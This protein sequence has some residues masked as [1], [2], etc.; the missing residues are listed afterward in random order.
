[1]FTKGFKIVN[2]NYPPHCSNGQFVMKIRA[3]GGKSRLKP[4]IILTALTILLR[5]GEMVA[6]E[7]YGF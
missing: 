5:R 3:C 4:E 6:W 7:F 2:P 1:M